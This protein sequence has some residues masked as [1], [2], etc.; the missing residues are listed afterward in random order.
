MAGAFPDGLFLSN[1]TSLTVTPTAT[2]TPPVAA[3][4][5]GGDISI[6]ANGDLTLSGSLSGNNVTL[7]ANVGALTSTSGTILT[8]TGALNLNARQIGDS[9]AY[10]PDGAAAAA[11]EVLQ[12]NATTINAEANSGGI[13]ISNASTSPLTLTAGAVRAPSNGAATNN[14]EIYSAG[15][16]RHCPAKDRSDRFE[17]FAS[18]WRVQSRGGHGNAFRRRDA[19][20]CRHD[21]GVRCPSSTI[22]SN[23]TLTNANSGKYYD[24]EA[25]TFLI[26]GS[27]SPVATSTAATGAGYGPL[28]VQ[29]NT[30]GPPVSGS[31]AV[32][33]PLE[34]TASELAAGGTFTASSII[35]DD[36]GIN[37]Q[38]GVTGQP[39]GV[40]NGQPGVLIISNSLTLIATAG[41]I[42]FLNPNDT[43]VVTG[44]GNTITV[45]A[46]TTTSANGTVST[47]APRRLQIT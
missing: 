19:E 40:I 29:T 12:T 20:L 42:V 23:T 44:P 39:G 17:R 33:A 43:I 14:I 2:V 16:Y 32:A 47:L 11:N 22:T 10:S 3:G 7:T 6:A 18:G 30:A 41:S 37:N 5:I 38:V 34:L 1:S 25:S 13:Y 45:E 36:L 28:V 8:A 24:V 4:N 21:V 26:D 15:E 31:Q 27:S 9:S 46:G 35:I